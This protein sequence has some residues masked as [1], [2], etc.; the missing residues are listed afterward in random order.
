MA[1][2][3]AVALARFDVVR[4][5]G[6]SETATYRSEGAEV[7]VL[8]TAEARVYE[9]ADGTGASILSEA[10]DFLITAADLVL[11]GRTVVPRTGDRLVV[12]TDDRIET[13][14]VASPGPGVACYEAVGSVRS[15]K[16]WRIHTKRIEET[17]A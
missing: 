12:E 3:R 5:A 6:F 14:E 10:T 4:R 11:G 17:E 8:A 7:A 1:D 9:V 15:P 13:F 2:R 16:I